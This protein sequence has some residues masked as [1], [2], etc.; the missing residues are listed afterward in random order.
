MFNALA[1]ILHLVAINIWVGGMFFIIIVLG[2]VVATLDIPGQH[3]FWKHLLQ[4][5]F[6]WVWLAVVAL[7][8]SGIAMIVY[9]FGGILNAPPYILVMASFGLMMAMVYFLIYFVFYQRFQH[10]MQNGDSESCRRQLKIIRRLGIVNMVLGFCV[11]VV[12]GGGPYA[13]F[14][15]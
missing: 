14:L 9:R 2:K 7:L 11:V 13:V 1:I 12:I 5:F 6:F 15:R 8:G 4:R 3:V 10:D